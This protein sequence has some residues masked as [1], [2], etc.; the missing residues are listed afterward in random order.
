MNKK[1]G[2]GGSSEI[3]TVIDL[4]YWDAEGDGAAS[5]LKE[6]VV[7]LLWLLQESCFSSSLLPSSL[8]IPDSRLA[9]VI[10]RSVPSPIVASSFSRKEAKPRYNDSELGKV[11]EEDRRMI[12]SIILIMVD[13]PFCKNFA[14][15]M[16][17]CPKELA[18]DV[19]CKVI[20]DIFKTWNW[21]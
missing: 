6:S 9:P 7:T 21:I 12:T 2:T 11:S 16:I 14:L 18:L 15:Y 4:S 5:F 8:R 10:W 17:C 20:Y 19:I 1:M 13:T 3:K